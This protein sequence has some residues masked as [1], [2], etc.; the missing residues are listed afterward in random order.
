MWSSR[1]PRSLNRLDLPG[2]VWLASDIHLGPATPATRQAF[3]RFLALAGEQAD[4]LLLCGDIFDAWIG[5]DAALSDPPAW[6]Q[7]SLYEM[8]LTASKIPVWIGRGNRDF[9]M[10]PAL[11]KHV[12]AQLLDDV[13]CLDTDYGPVLVSHGDEYCTADAGYQRFKRIVRNKWVQRAYLALGLRQ[14]RRIA[15]YA[16]RRSMS[17]HAGKRPDIMDVTPPAIEQAFRRTGARAMV[18]GHTHRPAR[19]DIHIDGQ[20]LTRIVLPDWD[21][22]HGEKRGGWAVIDRHGIRLEQLRAG[23]LPAQPA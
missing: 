18:H 8:A 13:V 1:K 6:L 4:A 11:A 9:L 16:R 15:D 2:K 19:H 7:A 21:F 10:G 17:S 14:R 23:L 22:D 20:M 3:E 5:D 12:H